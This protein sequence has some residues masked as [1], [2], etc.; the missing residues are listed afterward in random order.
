MFDFPFLV[1]CTAEEN[2]RFHILSQGQK[3]WSS[4]C[5][6]ELKVPA[7]RIKSLTM[8]KTRENSASRAKKKRSTKIDFRPFPTNTIVFIGNF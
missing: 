3:L 6:N 8:K 2:L 5:Y 4:S 7:S 1:P